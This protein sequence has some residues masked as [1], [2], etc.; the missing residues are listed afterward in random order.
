[1]TQSALA[2][3]PGSRVLVIFPGALGDLICFAPAL[4][5][6]AR[7]HPAAT[8]ELMA[9]A[10]LARFAAPRLGVAR[11]HSIDR[12][13]MSLLFIGDGTRRPEVSA[14]FGAFDRTYSFF[15]ASDQR[16]RASLAAASENTVSFHPFRPP[17]GGHVAACYLRA[18]GEEP[19]AS[20]APRIEVSRGDIESAAPVLE[21]LGLAPHRFVLLFPGSG[22]PAKN[23]PL[24][25]FRALARE[26]EAH[27]PALFVL[28]PAE[29]M[30]EIDLCGRGL[31]TVSG[32][33]LSEAAALASLARGFA[34]NDSGVSHL[35][36]AAGA[37]GVVLFGPT[38]P[39]RWRPLGRVEVIWRAALA[40]LT[41]AEVADSAVRLLV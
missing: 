10:E 11:G 17:G 5:A 31:R 32:L 28:G 16:F 33:Q 13:E 30:L 18:I 1:M 15:A 21:R 25:K 24:E 39:V 29:S 14:F 36:A 9:R 22:T 35:A 7:R 20:L 23:W 2:S 12:R 27:L 19:P 40:N 34:G 41:V 3:R 37:P 26:L 38:D 8:L 4:R 6:I